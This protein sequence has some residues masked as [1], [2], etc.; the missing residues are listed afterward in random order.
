MEPVPRINV[1]TTDALKKD[2]HE[3][4]DDEYKRLRVKF[5]LAIAGGEI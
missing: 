5:L 2:I 4:Y 1:E 3:R